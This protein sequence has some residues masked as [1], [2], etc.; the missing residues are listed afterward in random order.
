MARAVVSASLLGMLIYTLV[1]YFVQRP[2]D[3]AEF[4]IH[5]LL[6]TLIVVGVVAIV[7]SVTLHKVVIKPVSHVFIHLKRMAAGRIEK[8]DL[9]CRSD[10]I[11]SVVE[12]IN[13]LAIRLRTAGKDDVLSHALDDIRDIRA[14]LR[15]SLSDSDIDVTIMRNLAKL[16]NRLLDVLQQHSDCHHSKLTLRS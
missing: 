16:E 12:S 4:F 9:E 15:E 3:W 13:L 10:E 8:I 7:A 14:Q 1:E 6:H 11:R 5:H 2:D